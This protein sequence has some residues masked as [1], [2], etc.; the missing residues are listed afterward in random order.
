YGRDG[1]RAMVERHC[2]LAR[3]LADL[4]EE[5]ADME[6][7]ADVPLNVVCFRYR[8]EGV[9]EERLDALNRA[10]GEALLQDGR[11]FSGT[12]VYDG[13]VAL[14]PA[15]SNWRTT[16]DDLALLVDV[17]RELGERALEG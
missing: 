17:V 11:V 8:P 10:I 3:G 7:L 4:V 9:P 1:Y 2:E 12:T 16:A 14:R 6:L 5:S 13:M 15:I